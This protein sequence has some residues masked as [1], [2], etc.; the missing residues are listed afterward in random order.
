[1]K[2]SSDRIPKRGFTLLEAMIA[3]AILSLVLGTAITGTS[4][5]MA[6]LSARSDRAWSTELARSILDEYRVIGDRAL[7]QGTDPSG[8]HWQLEE[9]PVE[10]GLTEVIVRAWRG[11]ALNDAVELSYLKAPTR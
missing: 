6:R 1:M 9:R 8:F 4:W 10:G 11:R 7:A 3:M 2:L 5:T